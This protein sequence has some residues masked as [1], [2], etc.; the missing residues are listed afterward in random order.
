MMH[1][2]LKVSTLRGVHWYEYVIR[3]VIGGLITVMT[4][5]IA[6]IYGPVIGGLFLAFPAIFPATVTLIEK[7][8]REKKEHAGLTGAR[9]GK[10]AAALEAAGAA[11][12]SFGLMAF[13]AVVWLLLPL[14]NWP[15]FS[16]ACAAWFAAALLMWFTR[17]FVRVA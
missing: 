14:F 12:G 11:L 4:G 2:R 15:V 16:L 10:D 8:V 9:R 17:R 13:A 5:I 1:V 6:M 3:F 7:Q